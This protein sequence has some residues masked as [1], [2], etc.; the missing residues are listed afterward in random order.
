[1][2]EENRRSGYRRLLSWLAFCRIFSAPNKASLPVCLAF[3]TRLNCSSLPNPLDT[4]VVDT[5]ERLSSSGTVPRGAA[6]SGDVF[7]RGCIRLPTRPRA[8]GRCLLLLFPLQNWNTHTHSRYL[9]LERAASAA[10]WPVPAFYFYADGDTCC[11]SMR[12]LGP[13][14]SSDRR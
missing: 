6:L 1:M 9:E 12:L 7:S 11:A 14:S 3:F 2:A 13:W 5:A 8:R 10:A 4:D